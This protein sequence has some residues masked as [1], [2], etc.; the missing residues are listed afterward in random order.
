RSALRNFPQV[1]FTNAANAFFTVRRKPYPEIVDDGPR[2]SGEPASGRSAELEHGL[3][4]GL[5]AVVCPSLRPLERTAAGGALDDD[6]GVVAQRGPQGD[7]HLLERLGGDV[8]G[9]VEEHERDRGDLRPV[10]AR[11]GEPAGS[12]RG[13]PRPDLDAVGQAEVARG[14]AKL[15]DRRAVHLDQQCVL[16]AAG[17]GLEGEGPGAC[18]EI[19]HAGAGERVPALESIEQRLTDL[20]RGGPG[21][22]PGRPRDGAAS[23]A[24]GDDARHVSSSPHRGRA[25]AGGAGWAV[26]SGSPATTAKASSRACSMARASRITSRCL[27]VRCRPDCS[28]PTR[29]PAP[30]R[31]RSSSA[32]AKPSAASAICW[33][34]W[35]WSL[36]TSA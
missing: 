34:C 27:S 21:A 7:Q 16:G 13:L 31:R 29:S 12:G 4:V 32:R 18:V 19:E 3:A 36:P 22:L 26:S 14:A 9:R 33:R 20:V 10:L 11:G 17:D 23:E 35:E 6:E 28:S 25:P 5:G 8:V 1:T 2:L 15:R 24:A 30:R